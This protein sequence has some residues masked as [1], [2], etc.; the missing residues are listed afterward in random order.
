MKWWI[1]F[2][3][4][5]VSWPC[6]LQYFCTSFLIWEIFGYCLLDLAALG[7]KRL[8]YKWAW[9]MYWPIMEEGV[10]ALKG[11][12]SRIWSS[13]WPP[14]QRNQWFLGFTLSQG[15]RQN[16]PPNRVRYPANR[17]FASSSSPPGLAT[18]QLP[19]TTEL[20]HT[21]TRTCTVLIE[22]PHGRTTKPL[23]R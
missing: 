23:T 18:T 14:L 3:R 7:C 21:P 5:Y 4:F 22:R 8:K 16:I 1:N 20:W 13:L 17:Q 6:V 10:R 11:V 12:S 19:S 9:A 2:L 15:A